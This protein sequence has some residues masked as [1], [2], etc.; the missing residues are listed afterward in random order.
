MTQEDKNRLL[1]KLIDKSIS[2]AEYR[3]LELAA[4]DDVFLFDAI[5]G[6]VLTDDV[7]HSQIEEVHS[8]IN[9]SLVQRKK[10]TNIILLLTSIAA[11]CLLILYFVNGADEDI[12]QKNTIVDNRPQINGSVGS[13]HNDT[14]QQQASLL[15]DKSIEADKNKIRWTNTQQ[16]KDTIAVNKGIASVDA[17]SQS[18]TLADV[19]V[20][21]NSNANDQKVIMHETYKPSS[22]AVFSSES[23]PMKKSKMSANKISVKGKVLNNNGDPIIGAKVITQNQAVTTKI[24]GT[25][26][27]DLANIKNFAVIA[28]SGYESQGMSFAKDDDVTIFLKPAEPIK[29]LALESD[30]EAVYFKNFSLKI[31]NKI[32]KYL[33]EE[34]IKVMG[35]IIIYFQL[36]A[37]GSVNDF[38]F[39]NSFDYTVE[40][41]IK[42]WI[43]EE[44]H[45]LP[46]SARGEVITLSF[47]P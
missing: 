20:S 11:A 22:P 24:D 3:A 1:K 23:Q 43:I 38:I 44:K 31:E 36:N 15:T 4:L 6:Y 14:A 21:S 17:I 12:Q 7:H 5:E 37:D 39:Q 25:F 26:N 13:K 8:K 10:P 30:L 9:E 46:A 35:E 45:L 2:A 42:K 34:N 40:E 29:D 27:L 47:E 41:A 19:V 16:L 33:R 32:D 18:A 28:Q